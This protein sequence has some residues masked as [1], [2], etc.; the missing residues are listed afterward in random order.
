MPV[1]HV[2]R[3][4]KCGQVVQFDKLPP[5]PVKCTS[6]GTNMVRKLN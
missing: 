1:M 5:M 6:C 3:C 4:P 2:F